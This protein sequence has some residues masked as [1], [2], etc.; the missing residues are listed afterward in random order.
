MDMK[1]ARQAEVFNLTPDEPQLFIVGCIGYDD[2]VVDCR[3]PAR[4]CSVDWTA[5]TQA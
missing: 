5:G 1:V 4:V 3:V 2:G